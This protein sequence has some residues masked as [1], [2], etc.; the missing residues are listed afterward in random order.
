MGQVNQ[1]PDYSAVW[2]FRLNFSAPEFLPFR[3]AAS[4]LMGEGLVAET[5]DGQIYLTTDGYN[6]CKKHYK[7]FSSAGKWFPNDSLN[8]ENL[9][10]IVGEMH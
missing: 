2:T 4:K 7:E 9:K 10:R 6:Y 3:E 5:P 1:F 8:E